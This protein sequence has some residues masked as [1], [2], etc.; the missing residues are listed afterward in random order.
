MWKILCMLA[1]VC[2]AAC[3]KNVNDDI[4]EAISRN[5]TTGEILAVA[6]NQSAALAVPNYTVSTIDELVAAL[7][8]AGRGQT[9]YISDN[10]VINCNGLTKSL[11]L[12]AG[13]TLASGL[14]FDANFS[15]SASPG[16]KLYLG[17]ATLTS[18]LRVLGDSVTIRGLRIHGP[19]RNIEGTQPI[20]CG[21]KVVDYNKLTIDNCEIA[22]WSYAGINFFNSKAGM[23][24][25]SYI[26]HNRRTG[27]GFGILL[28]SA[29]EVVADRNLLDNNRHCI[30]GS[31]HRTQ[32]YEIRNSI[33]R[34]T[35][36]YP[37]N[38]S[39]CDM[40]GES[41]MRNGA[42][43]PNSSYAGKKIWIHHNSIRNSTKPA[44]VIRG[45]PLER[46]L[47]EHNTFDHASVDKAIVQ[48]LPKTYTK[49]TSHQFILPPFNNITVTNNAWL[50]R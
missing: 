24:T 13:I 32:S 43:F 29:A 41:E 21:I 49:T 40:H 34:M 3:K 26:H 46:S 39:L 16:A 9:I 48:Y 7:K 31:G 4:E 36:A 45:I 10:A 25:N 2:L 5:H 8:V 27:L 35:E 28:D 15:A 38:W 20:S 14:R 37:Y 44:I 6:N 1:I 22:G 23:V 42:T 12:P 47:I 17:T 33:L 19:D 30:A 18:L 50:N 11:Y